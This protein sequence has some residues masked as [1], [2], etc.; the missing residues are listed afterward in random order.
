MAANSP[1]DG[2]SIEDWEP[3]T[4]ELIEEH[5]L[6]AN[7]IYSIVLHVWDDI[8]KSGIGSKPFKIGQDLFPRPQIMGYFLHELI[9]LE[10]EYRYPEL[11]RREQTSTEKDIVYMPD[12]KYSVEIK[13]S[14]SLRNIYGNRSYAQKTDIHKK[15]KS[16]Y[17]LAINFEKFS[18]N[19]SLPKVSL[20]RFGWIDYEDWQGQVAASGQQSRLSPEV[21]KYKLLTLPLAK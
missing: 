9:P 5:P 13:T 17:Y 7:E 6:D 14:S 1:Y 4:L 15:S 16:G 19:K 2:L 8:L 21:E 12:P 10:L 11:W 20:V 3:K 18:P